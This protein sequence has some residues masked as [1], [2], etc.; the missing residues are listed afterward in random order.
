[1]HANLGRKTR[2]KELLERLKKRWDD[3]VKMYM[4][5]IR[6]EGNEMLSSGP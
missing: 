5:G 2:R 4:K 1:M 6:Q 3:I